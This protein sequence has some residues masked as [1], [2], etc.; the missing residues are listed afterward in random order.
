MSDALFKDCPKCG[1]KVHV[2]KKVCPGC[3][4][5][6]KK[7]LRW[8]HWVLI[9]MAG[10]IVLGAMGGG[11]ET[12]ATAVGEKSATKPASSKPASKPG[13]AV[14]APQ[15]EFVDTVLSYK[16]DFRKAQNELQQSSVRTKRRQALAGLG[17]GMA[18]E[19][20]VGKIKRMETTTEGHAVLAVTIG[21]NVEIHTWNNAFAD[22]GVGTLISHESP[23]YDKL[24]EMAR[25]QQI[26]FSGSF[27]PS[28]DDYYEELSLTIEGSMSQ[29]EFLF[30]FSDVDKIE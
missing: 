9:V 26:K 2:S 23:L 24:S 11:E 5:K 8:F 15:K 27:L 21:D 18:V 20:W 13:M 19:N 16:A 1:E 6:N 28:E 17:L 14:P 10:L 25:G 29:P 7:K 4:H 12:T 30:K 3:G 22:M